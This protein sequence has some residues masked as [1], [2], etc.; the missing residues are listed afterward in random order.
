MQSEKTHPIMCS[1][2][3]ETF[4]VTN[5]WDSDWDTWGNAETEINQ[6]PSSFDTGKLSTELAGKML[7]RS[8]T[9]LLNRLAAEEKKSPLINSYTSLLAATIVSIESHMAG[10]LVLS[11]LLYIKSCW[12]QRSSE[13]SMTCDVRT[14]LEKIANDYDSPPPIER[15]L[16]QTHVDDVS[17]QSRALW[18]SSLHHARAIPCRATLTYIK[19]DTV[20]ATR[21]ARVAER[22]KALHSRC[23][24][25]GGTGS[26]PVACKLDDIFL[27]A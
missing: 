19:M 9:L 20:V 12:N 23:G 22:S 21:T 5:T 18:F 3:P 8:C 16:W 2:E 14:L 15:T 27:H 13:D 26:S 4:V 17:K 25:F 6:T 11:D 1:L 10:D 24:L 7:E